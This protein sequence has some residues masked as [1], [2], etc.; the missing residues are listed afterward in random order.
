MRLLISASWPAREPA[1]AL[2]PALVGVPAG[3]EATGTELGTL[4]GAGET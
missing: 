2:G 3:P 1:P 4:V